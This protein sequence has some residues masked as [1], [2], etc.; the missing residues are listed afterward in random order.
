MGN[1]CWAQFKL[2]DISKGLS[3]KDVQNAVF[4]V[5]TA[6]LRLPKEGPRFMSLEEF[7]MNKEYGKDE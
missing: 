1:K 4:S 3:I 7:I 5:F 2:T 6:P